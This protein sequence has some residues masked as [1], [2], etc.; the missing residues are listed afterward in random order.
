MSEKIE[1]G[2]IDIITSTNINIEDYIG[3]IGYN[4]VEDIGREYDYLAFNM[5]NPVLSNPE[6]IV[7]TEQFSKLDLINQKK[8]YMVLTKLKDQYHK[9]IIINF[10]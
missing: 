9:I 6:V 4:K 7:L 8:I 2:K 5:E 3:T 1:V 10:F